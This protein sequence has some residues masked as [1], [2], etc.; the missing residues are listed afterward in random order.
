MAA[1]LQCCGAPHDPCAY[2]CDAPCNCALGDRAIDVGVAAHQLTGF[3]AK[4][5]SQ[6]SHFVTVNFKL[7]KMVLTIFDVLHGEVIVNSSWNAKAFRDKVPG[8]SVRCGEARV[9]A[10]AIL[11]LRSSAC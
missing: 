8:A 5:D 4:R 2:R 7:F 6:P 1:A 9:P 11:C 10:F 3:S